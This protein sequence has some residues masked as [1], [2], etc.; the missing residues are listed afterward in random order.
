MNIS[1]PRQPLDGK[2]S[3]LF[4]F[5]YPLIRL[6]LLL[7]FE[8]NIVFLGMTSRSGAKSLMNGQKMDHAAYP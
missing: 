2:Q 6:S 7:P 8:E 3:F 5:I 1:D 4:Y